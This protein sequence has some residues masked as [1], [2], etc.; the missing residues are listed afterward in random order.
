MSSQTIFHKGMIYYANAI[1]I[2]YRTLFTVCF[3]QRNVNIPQSIE[4]R[5]SIFIFHQ[6][7]ICLRFH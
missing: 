7:L 1:K 3:W 2:L 5:Y 4:L 6:P